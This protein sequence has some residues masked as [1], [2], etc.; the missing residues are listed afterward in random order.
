MYGMD[1][2]ITGWHKQNNTMEH[3]AKRPP[4]V[5]DYQPNAVKGESLVKNCQSYFTDSICFQL[6]LFRDIFSSFY[7]F[8]AKRVIR[9]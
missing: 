3:Q 6:D 1:A 8:Q 4:T 9:A 5:R 2:S 7:Y